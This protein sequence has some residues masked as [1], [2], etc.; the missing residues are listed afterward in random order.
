MWPLWIM[1]KN[2]IKV[3][4]FLSFKDYSKRKDRGEVKDFLFWGVEEKHRC[5]RRFTDFARSSL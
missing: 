5:L 4:F 3:V 2:N 1:H